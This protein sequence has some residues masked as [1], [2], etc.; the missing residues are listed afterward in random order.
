MFI[1]LKFLYLCFYYF[2]FVIYM[3]DKMG[4]KLKG[5]EDGCCWKEA[6]ADE[7]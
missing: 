6:I 1:S 4:L 2:S 5:L 7:V 3:D